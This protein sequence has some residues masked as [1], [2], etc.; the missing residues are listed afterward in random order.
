MES[1]Q[2]DDYLRR[3]AEF[4]RLN[5]QSLAY[6]HS[7]RPPPN[8]SAPDILNPFTW[9]TTPLKPAALSID[10][11]RLFYVLMRIDALSIN[12]GSLDTLIL[13]PSRPLVY[14]NLFPQQD[15]SD[16]LSLASLRSSLSMVSSL[17]LGASWWARSEPPSVDNDIKFLYSS[18]T[19]LPSLILQA[20]GPRVIAE[21]MNESLNNNAIPLDAFKNLQGL[22][23]IDV[24]PRAILGWDR[25]AESL[26]SLKIQRSG[27]GD[28]SDIFFHAV[29]ADEARRTTPSAVLS[30]PLPQPTTPEDYDTRR[31]HMLGP[32][33]WAFLRH[34]ALPEN[35]LT[36]FPIESMPYLSA[37]THLDLSC[38]LLVSVPPGLSALTKLVSLNLADNMIDSVLGIYLNLGQVLHLN[39]AY[40]RLESLCGLERLYGLERVNLSGNLLEDSAEVGRLALLPN[41][42]EVYVQGNPF[43]DIQ[44]NYRVICFDYFW[45]EGKSI[46]LDGASPSYYERR[47][48]ST[49]PSIQVPAPRSAEPVANSPP[50]VPVHHS[51]STTPIYPNQFGGVDNLLQTPKRRRLKR[52]VN[53]DLPDEEAENNARRM[54]GGKQR[55]LSLTRPKSLLTNEEGLIIDSVSS[56]PGAPTFSSRTH[57]R[58]TRHWTEHNLGFKDSSSLA[59][60]TESPG[61]AQAYLP[62]T[63][64]T[65][66]SRAE[67]RRSRVSATVHESSVGFGEV[68]SGEEGAEAYRKRIEALRKDMGDGWLKVFS[69]SETQTPK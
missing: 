68:G 25:L 35:S 37:L 41:I 24:D 23:C 59:N 53:L 38:N 47:S 13:N 57:G 16:T 4:I 6:G 3:L 54:S 65:L 29:L 9:L 15:N 22:S 64:G 45:K 66:V 26:K 12:V 30:S 60:I 14:R 19:K 36:F 34:L 31:H 17:S 61:S 48:L 40:N 55:S 7:L 58:H 52:I 5:Q 44:E 18:F 2:G 39:L 27:L 62:Q 51:S 8:F 1:E 10:I 69:Q 56:I 46:T 28:V 42:S 63:T 50:V 49:P 20:P 33:K 67:K 21:T 32:L 11:H 43:I